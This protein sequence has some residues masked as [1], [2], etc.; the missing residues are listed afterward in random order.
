MTN[1]FKIEDLARLAAY[2]DGE[3]HISI[4]AVGKR[5][6]PSYRMQI[7]VANTDLRLMVWLK[8]TFG[9]EYRDK[10]L[11]KK[12]RRAWYWYMSAGKASDLLALCLP[13]FIM[14]RDQAEIAIT[15]QAEVLN[16]KSKGR[17]YLTDEMVE[18]RK[19]Y[20]DA[21]KQARE[22]AAPVIN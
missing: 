8:S 5:K 22:D 3:G 20:S 1:Q 6:L 13:Y 2:I 10:C 18:A 12:G 16:G 11:T 4:E 21:I 14:K 19:K 17:V 15:F 7:T 9:G